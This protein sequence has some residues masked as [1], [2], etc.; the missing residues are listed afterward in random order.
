MDK[1]AAGKLSNCFLSVWRSPQPGTVSVGDESEDVSPSDVSVDEVINQ[2]D[3][4]NGNSSV[5]PDIIQSRALKEFKDEIAK[6][7]TVLNLL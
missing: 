3:K 6:L 5:V 7:L 1:P 4:I 2:L